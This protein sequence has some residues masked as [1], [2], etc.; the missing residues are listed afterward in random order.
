MPVAFTMGFPAVIY[1]VIYR[2]EWLTI[3]PAKIFSGIDVFVFLAIPFFIMAGE[4]MSEFNITDRI[5]EFVDAVVGH[6]RGGLAQVNVF[7][8]MFF[9]GV[10]GA[11]LADI[12]A[13]GSI[14]IPAMEKDGYS[15][16][17]AAALT[18]VTSLQGPI[19]PPSIIMVVYA[20]IM[21]ISVGAMFAAGI[22]PGVLLGLSDCVIVAFQAKA[23]G[24]PKRE[25]PFS[26]KRLII[27]FWKS[28]PA[29]V[30][31]ALIVSGILGGVFTPTEAGAVTVFY[32]F[33][34]GIF[35]LGGF[36]WNSII[37]ILKSTLTK[38]ATLFIIVAFATLFSWVL[39]MENIP[40]AIGQFLL[41][42]T[43]NKYG[44]LFIM[45]IVFLFMGTW[46][47][48]TAALILMGPIFAQILNGLGVH[49]L[50]YGIV[51]VVNLVIG[52]VTPPFGV[53]LF[54]V[55]SLSGCTIEEISKECFPFIMVN[56]GVLFLITYFP[57]LVLFVPRLFKLA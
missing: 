31:P 18:A 11:A 24:F 48:T 3:V 43:N 16:K 28:M 17:Y 30:I 1:M 10:S 51:M 35:F 23:R 14:V 20:S 46:L 42:I 57:D 40:H 9:G 52:L 45:N 55:S 56:I 41:S 27:T 15:R 49:P 36:H 21:G 25:T 44:V 7:D 13:L 54:A 33:F 38:T 34:L 19:I 12:A 8:S 39:A 26:L 6:V 53:C 37:R 5:I 29:L 50:H 4:I 22:V 2:P 47:E 32:G